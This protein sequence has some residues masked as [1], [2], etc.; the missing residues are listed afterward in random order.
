M[1]SAAATRSTARLVGIER[2]T[3]GS[4]SLNQGTRLALAASTARLSLGEITRLAAH[5]HIAVA[6]AIGGGAEIGT[7]GIGERG[8]EVGG[9]GRVR[10]GMVAAEIGQRIGIDRCARRGPEP[11]LENLPRIGP[12]YR[13][14]R[15]EAEPETAAEQV[16]Q[17]VEVENPLHQRGVV[18]DR[19]DD[20]DG[21]VAEPR[22]AD[23]VERQ[24]GRLDRAIGGDALRA[25][26]DC[27][28]HALGRW[29]AIGDIVLDAEIAVGAA[30][31]VAGRQH[32]AAERAAA[33][34][35][36]TGRRGGQQTAAADQD[37]G[38]AVRGH[39][40]QDG[41]RR[42]GIKKAAIAAQHQRFP[43]DPVADR[44]GQCVEDRLDERLKVAGLSE[45]RNLF[46]QPGRAGTL[47]GKWR[48][49]GVDY[50]HRVLATV[51]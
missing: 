2:A 43:G 48:D 24:V 44:L 7:S 17:P 27:L 10:V 35:H 5:H 32:D 31:I 4:P 1:P 45:D 19:I 49:R 16:A 46:A 36:C 37:A 30:G 6:V 12:G 9:I 20:F 29:A 18:G 28:G 26:V 25:A 39:Q 51:P 23:A 3:P 34:D 13:V 42:L 11:P 47:V 40:A 14:H 8:D 21:H 15:I 22:R 33:P 41:L 50:T 38:D